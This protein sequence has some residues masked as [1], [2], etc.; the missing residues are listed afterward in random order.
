M[1]QSSRRL[2][3]RMVAA[4]LSIALLLAATVAAFARLWPALERPAIPA[5]LQSGSSGDPPPLTP[6]LDPKPEEPAPEQVVTV[7]A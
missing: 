4:L 3:L 2:P 6:I 1:D 7:Y 5:V